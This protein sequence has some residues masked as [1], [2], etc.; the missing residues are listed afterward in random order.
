M[1]YYLVRR[2]GISLVLL[3][4]VSVISF[5]II[6]FAPGAKAAGGEEMNQKKS[7]AAEQARQKKYHM[8]ERWYKQYVLVMRDL[9]TNRLVDYNDRPVQ[10]Q[11][12]D[13]LP[14]TMLLNAVS[15]ILVFGLGIPLGVVGARFRGGWRDTT[16]AVGAF[17][18][19]ALP[20]FFV[21]YMLCILLVKFVQVP[22]LG[23]STYGMHFSNFAQVVL[24]TGWH[25]FAP[26][27]VL[28]LGGIA[29]QSRYVRASLIESLSEDYIRTA[30]AKGL[31]ESVVYYRHALRNSLRPMVTFFG[32]L[33]AGMIAGSVVVEQIFSYPGMGRLAYEA[34]IKRNLPVLVAINFYSAVLVVT[35]NL[36]ADLLYSVVDP[37][38][39]LE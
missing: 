23:A 3:A 29:V 33:L 19:L 22:I 4:I 10:E 6:R 38:V 13:R 39:R 37:R 32:F 12:I 14:M 25:L 5:A 34:L 8:D 28:A 21:A 27:L 1:I 36:L 15:L 7:L 17:F 16:V 18:L 24:D 30:R 31:P 2:M 35:G 26:A 20:G 9:L 11:I